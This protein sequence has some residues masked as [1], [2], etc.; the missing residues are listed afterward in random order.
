[1][2]Y[3]EILLL[4]MFLRVCHLSYLC[5]NLV[6]ILSAILPSCIVW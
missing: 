2:D 3:R 6:K 4:L 5:Q 1:M